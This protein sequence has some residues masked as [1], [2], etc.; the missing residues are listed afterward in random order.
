MIHAG[1][2]PLPMYARPHARHPSTSVPSRAIQA[3]CDLASSRNR[4]ACET[5]APNAPGCDVPRV[6]HRA[7]LTAWPRARRDPGAS[8]RVQRAPPRSL[9]SL[10]PSRPRAT[11]TPATGETCTCVPLTRARTSRVIAPHVVRSRGR[12]L[13][14]ASRT[15]LAAWCQRLPAM[16]HT[17]AH[18]D[19]CHH[20]PPRLR[21]Q[22]IG[23]GCNRLVLPAYPHLRFLARVPGSSPVPS[24]ALGAT[25]WPA[26]GYRVRL[27]G[28]T[29]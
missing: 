16:L 20:A 9:V 25:L 14:G 5:C 26:F 6:W 22:G 29:R 15:C 17:T 13:T 3:R 24:S 28:M 23:C 2:H 10:V 27:L 4:R 11:T 18:R 8:W 19:A 7:R 1:A 21:L 12:Y